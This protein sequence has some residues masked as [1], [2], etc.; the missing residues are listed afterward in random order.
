MLLRRSFSVLTLLLIVF[1]IIA[2][3]DGQPANSPA[4][5]PELP[6]D[7]PT[8]PSPS[9]PQAGS[10]A[11]APLSPFSSPPA[12]PPSDGSSPAMS[13]HLPSESPVPSPSPSEWDDFNHSGV[14]PEKSSGGGMSGGKKFGIAF[15]VIVL[16]GLVI[17]GG[18]VY[19]KRQDNIRR[20]RYNY[21]A[22]ADIL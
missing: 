15:G 17:F 2:A 1:S 12:P 10:P 19:K 11:S 16:A 7:A 6:A 9:P 8:A 21:A 4:P 3:S 20:A 13:P 22:G 14:D 5:A 18:L